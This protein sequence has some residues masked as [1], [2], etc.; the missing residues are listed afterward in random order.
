MDEFREILKN[1]LYRDKVKGMSKSKY[2][3]DKLH[4]QNKKGM[5]TRKYVGN[6]EHRRRVIADN[7]LTRQHV[8]EGQSS[9]TWLWSIF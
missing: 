4:R 2:H 1:V 9:L 6:V 3:D 7:K 8:K 5:S